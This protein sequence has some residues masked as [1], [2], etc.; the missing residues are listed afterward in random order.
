MFLKQIDIISPKITFYYN[1][2]LA[3]SSIFSGILSIIA[4]ILIIAFSAPFINDFIKKKNLNTFYFNSFIEDAPTLMINSTSLFHFVSLEIKGHYQINVGLDFTVFRIIGSSIPFQSKTDI[5]MVNH[6]LYGVCNNTDAEGINDLISY[7]SF[8]KSACIKKYY[9]SK[10]KKYYD[11][12]HANFKYPSI[13]HGS[14]NDNNSIY[15]LFVLKCEDYMIGDILGE[16]FKCKT[17]EEMNQYFDNLGET[18]VFEFYFLNNYV[19]ISSYYNPINKFIYRIDT[20]FYPNHY[21][22]NYLNINPSK[23]ITNAGVVIDNSKEEE[24]YMFERNDAYVVD[25]ENGNMY[26]VY[27]F[28]LKNIINIYERNYSKIYEIISD[29]GGVFE[30]LLMIVSFINSIYNDYISLYD[31]SEL[32]NFLIDKEKNP[33]KDENNINKEQIKINLNNSSLTSNKE[34]DKKY[35]ANITK[36][37]EIFKMKPG[38]LP[39]LPQNGKKNI[40]KYSTHSEMFSDENM[41]SDGKKIKNCSTRL[42]DEIIDNNIIN[43]N[44]LENKKSYFFGYILYLITCKKKNNFYSIYNNFREKIISEEHLF[45]NHLKIYNLSRISKTNKFIPKNSYKINDLIFSL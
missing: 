10:T 34:E 31:T 24:T 40:I 21:T 22:A 23:V 5:K 25:K 39:H 12:G 43:G 6:W 32:L 9:D 42:P 15:N 29:I 1:G 30:I 37:E 28:I 17:T 26:V 36:N 11:K 44:A 18:K 2:S 8:N 41:N 33:L 4:I 16:G 45:R 20:A 38:C 35:E 13:S 19:N 7:D 3:H 27:S 14:F